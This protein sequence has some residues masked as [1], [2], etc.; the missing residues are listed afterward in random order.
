MAID[1]SKVFE[2]NEEWIKE[3]LDEDPSFFDNLSRGQQPELLFLGC[4]VRML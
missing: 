3:K 4:S 1:I 2:N